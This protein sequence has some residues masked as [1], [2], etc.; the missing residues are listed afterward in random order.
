MQWATASVNSQH[1]STQ[2]QENFPE[3]VKGANAKYFKA[4]LLGTQRKLE[5]SRFVKKG[6]G[7]K[8]TTTTA[9]RQS[10]PDDLS[11]ESSHHECSTGVTMLQKLFQC[12]G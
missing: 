7:P 11:K 9:A 2:P 12:S 4:I 6:I 8:A 1:S 5:P 3:R 10:T